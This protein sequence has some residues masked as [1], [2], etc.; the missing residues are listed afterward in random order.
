MTTVQEKKEAIVIDESILE[1]QKFKLIERQKSLLMDIG[2]VKKTRVKR[3]NKKQDV[4]TYESGEEYNLVKRYLDQIGKIPLLN[5]EEELMLTALA[6]KDNEQAKELLI[7]SNLRLVVS[8]AKRYIKSGM[9][10]DLIQEGTLGLIHSIGKF[11]YKK[12]YKFST[13]ATWWINQAVSRYLANHSR[14]VRIPVNVVENINKIKQASKKLTR[15]LGR[16]PSVEE[17]AG[18]IGMPIKKV[19]KTLSS[20]IMPISIDM[21]INDDDG[22]MLSEIIEDNKARTPEEIVVERNMQMDVIDS[23]NMLNEKEKDIVVKHFG[24]DGSEP[25]NLS[26]ISK[27]YSLTRERIRQ[28][29]IGAFKKIRTSDVAS[30][31]VS[32]ISCN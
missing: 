29:E 5:R 20:E 4:L 8:I 18:F 32:Y 19:E 27:Q 12:G 30:K 24:L 13:Y 2:T 25:M 9:F 7:L 26:E 3:R 22:S 23:L 28:I 10:I 6:A 17:I 11:E 31:L 14:L 16:E 21:Q 15:D 1:K